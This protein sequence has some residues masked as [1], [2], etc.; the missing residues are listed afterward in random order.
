MA[1]RTSE[2]MVNNVCC[3]ICLVVLVL[4]IVLLVRQSASCEKFFNQGQDQQAASRS[5]F[6]R[7]MAESE[8]R[9]QGGPGSGDIGT[10]RGYRRGL[11]AAQNGRLLTEIRSQELLTGP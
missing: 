10:N 2:N 1:R 7:L 6:R 4:V 11:D 5:A 3:V 9:Q 8:G